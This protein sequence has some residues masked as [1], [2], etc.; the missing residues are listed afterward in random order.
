MAPILNSQK[1]SNNLPSQ[2]SYRALIE[3]ALVKMLMA[4]CYDKTTLCMVDLDY[5]YVCHGRMV[6]MLA[7]TVSGDKFALS[8]RVMMV[9]KPCI[10][11]WSNS[12]RNGIYP[13]LPLHVH[14][15]SCLLHEKK[16][17][18]RGQ[19]TSASLNQEASQSMYSSNFKVPLDPRKW[20]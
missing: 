10:I 9:S 12:F 5:H 14:M 13:L 7:T 19:E 15:F 11:T 16:I 20:T 2:V 4:K 8:P 17:P 1:T 3:S 6:S 18:S